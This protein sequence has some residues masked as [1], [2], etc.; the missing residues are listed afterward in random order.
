MRS[1][2]AVSRGID[3]LSSLVG[4]T[5]AWLAALMIFIGAA[6]A[7]LRYLSRD[8]GILVGGNAALEAQWYL[9]SLMFLLGAAW[10]LERDAHVR[11]DVLYGRL[12]PRNRTIVDLLG[13]LLF[14]LPFCVFALTVSGPTVWNSWEVREMSQDPGGLPRYP[15]KAVILVGFVLL[16]LQGISEVIKSVA[17]LVGQLPFPGDSTAE[18]DTP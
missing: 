2:L 9:F 18:E 13:A 11:V 17:R 1:L 3:R 6:N 16:G 10:T 4:H 8:L 5:T 12:S 7:I 14:L 15:I